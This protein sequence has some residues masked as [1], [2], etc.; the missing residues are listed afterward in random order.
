MRNFFPGDPEVEG[1]FVVSPNRQPP[2]AAIHG[3]AN[4][5]ASPFA[6]ESRSARETLQEIEVERA[7]SRLRGAS[8]RKS[9]E[10]VRGRRRGSSRDSLHRGASRAPGR[11]ASLVEEDRG[12]SRRAGFRADR[13]RPRRGRAGS[14]ALQLVCGFFRRSAPTHDR[15]YAVRPRGARPN[16]AAKAFALGG[17]GGPRSPR[18][19]GSASVS[20]NS[21][22]YSLVF[23]AASPGLL[24]VKT[25][26]REA[27]IE[28]SSAR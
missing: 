4:E 3:D 10:E 23:A 8:F 6:Q 16:S 13:G 15:G 5:S 7:R 24:I 17:R 20:G 22:R 9:V 28:V 1:L 21:S 25:I 26:A 2:N 12:A 19:A 14:T 11:R 18:P 27:E